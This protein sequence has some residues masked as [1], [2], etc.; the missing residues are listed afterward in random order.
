MRVDKGYTMPIQNIINPEGLTLG[1]WV[2][3]EAARSQLEANRLWDSL[4][5]LQPIDD[6]HQQLSQYNEICDWMDELETNPEQCYNKVLTS[7]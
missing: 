6:Y 4:D 2:V 5:A 1:Q 3:R 7:G